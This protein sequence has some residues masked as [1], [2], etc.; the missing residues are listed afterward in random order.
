M[1]MKK[2]FSVGLA[3]AMVMTTGLS[4][5]ASASDPFWTTYPNLTNYSN[6]DYNYTFPKGTAASQGL[7]VRGTDSTWVNYGYFTT[8]LLDDITWS[9]VGGSNPD[10]S[11]IPTSSAGTQVGSDYTAKTTV[12]VANNADYG[13]AVVEAQNPVG[14]YM[15][16]TIVVNPTSDIG[17]VSDVD[18]YAYNGSVGTSNLL[19]SSTGATVNTNTVN[20]NIKYPSAMDAI[21]AVADSGTEFVVDNSWGSYILTSVKIGSTNYV[22]SSNTSGPAWIYR[23]YDADGDIKDISEKAGAEVLNVEEGETV[24]WVYGDYSYEFPA[25]FPA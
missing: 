19:A 11:Y 18:V 8:A 2:M 1:K 7:E 17:P 12:S 23:V 25:T 14:G 5:F 22:N 4:A 24:V 15:D 10:V 13:L 21:A 9:L 16:F 3:A 6:T 20:S